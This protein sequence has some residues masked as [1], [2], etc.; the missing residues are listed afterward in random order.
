MGAVSAQNVEFQMPKSRLKAISIPNLA[1]KLCLS[2]RK[3]G[4]N[5]SEGCDSVT[6]YMRMRLEW[7]VKRSG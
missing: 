5:R 4:C 1:D 2:C 3:S 6:R 7:K